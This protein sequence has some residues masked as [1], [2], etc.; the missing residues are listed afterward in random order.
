MRVK[1]ETNRMRGRLTKS[2]EGKSMRNLAAN[3]EGKGKKN[4]NGQF[5]CQTI[6]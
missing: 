4:S 6:I 1:S 2:E 3:V 5:D